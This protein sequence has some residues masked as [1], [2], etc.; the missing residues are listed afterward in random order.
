[1]YPDNES[2]KLQKMGLVFERL[3]YQLRSILI[4][5]QPRIPQRAT[6]FTSHIATRTP[7]SGL[8]NVRTRRPTKQPSKEDEPANDFHACSRP[9]NKINELYLRFLPRRIPSTSKTVAASHRSDRTARI[10]GEI[11]DRTRRKKAERIVSCVDVSHHR[12]RVCLPRFRS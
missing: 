1:M 4:P 2:E 10:W 9:W 5:Y 7:Y 12:M 3:V 11:F 8:R 6:E